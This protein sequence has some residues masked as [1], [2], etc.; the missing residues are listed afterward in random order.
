MEKMNRTLGESNIN[1]NDSGTGS[2]KGSNPYADEAAANM[3]GSVK[4]GS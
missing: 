4:A 2:K 3:R 1:L